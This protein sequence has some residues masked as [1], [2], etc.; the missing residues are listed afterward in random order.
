MVTTAV[1]VM[2]R[3][4]KTAAIVP[5]PNAYATL[6][7]IEN[8]TRAPTRAMPNEIRSAPKNSRGSVSTPV[9]RIRKKIPSSAST[10]MTSLGSI[11]PST[12]GPR[13]TPI[14]SSPMMRGMPTRPSS[15]ATVHTATIK[16]S[17]S[18]KIDFTPRE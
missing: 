12:A 3:P 5:R 1:A 10:S 2:A 13:I 14:R 16:I 9:C 11:Q 4:T 15:T 8:G 7:P 6:M 18:Q 17:K